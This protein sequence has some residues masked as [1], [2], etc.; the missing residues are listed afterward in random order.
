MTMTPVYTINLDI[1]AISV[2]HDQCWLRCH[3]HESSGKARSGCLQFISGPPGFGKLAHWLTA[4]T[5]GDDPM[6]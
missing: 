5:Q 4:V 1:W 6:Y 2:L 3:D